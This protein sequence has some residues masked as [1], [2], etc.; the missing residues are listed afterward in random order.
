ML[1]PIIAALLF[2]T[3]ACCAHTQAAPPSI[4]STVI[5][6]NA[7]F[8]I[9]TD[10]LIR[11]EYSSEASFDDRATFTVINR[12]L[13]VPNFT[14]TGGG[15]NGDALI[16]TTAA[17]TLT[18][19]NDNTPLPPL[20]RECGGHAENEV[21]EGQDWSGGY[22][23]GPAEGVP[24]VDCCGACAADASCTSWSVE[25]KGGG[26]KTPLCF[27]YANPPILRFNAKMTA[28]RFPPTP[29]RFG[30]GLSISLKNGGSGATWTPA[31]S[32]NSAQL[33]GTFTD[34]GCY[35]DAMTCLS[36]YW[37]S[38]MNLG[39]V[40]RSG[41]VAIDDSNVPRYIDGKKLNAP[42]PLW[43]TPAPPLI[44]YSDLYI[45][46]YESD[47]VGFLRD[48]S[49]VSGAIA[50]PRRSALG[51]WYGRYYAVTEHDEDEILLAYANFS[52]PLAGLMLD[53]DWHIEP[54]L[55]CLSWG[56]YQWNDTLFPSPLNFSQRVHS[57]TTP[58]GHAVGVSLNIHPQTGIDICESSYPV[59]A[60]RMGINPKTNV[61]IAC[62]M[63]NTTFVQNLYDLILSRETLVI[64]DWWW[65]DFFGCAL[66][67]TG[68]TNVLLWTNILFS[69]LNSLRFP[70]KRPMVLSRSG[71][72][73]TQ[74]LPISFSGDTIQHEATLDFLLQTTP[75]ASNSLVPWWSHDVGG[76][77]IR[78]IGGGTPGDADP[79]NFTACLLLLRWYQ[80]S[81]TFPIF[82]QHCSHCERRIWLFPS[83]F[84][85]LADT[86]R[87]RAALVPY[88]YTS[89]K[90]YGHKGLPIVRPMYYSWPSLNG[91][92]DNNRQHMFGGDDILAAAVSTIEWS[93]NGGSSDNMTQRN[94]WLPP[95]N[96]THWD[97][98]SSILNGNVVIS[99]KVSFNSTPLFVRSGSLIPLASSLATTD[100]TS[101]ISPSLQW[102]LFPST[103]STT[104]KISSFV[105]EDDG[106]ETLDS[107]SGAITS[108]YVTLDNNTNNNI[109][110]LTVESMNGTFYGAPTTRGIEFQIRGWSLVSGGG[111]RLPPSLVSV[112]GVI[113]QP[114]TP[115][116]QSEIVGW[117]IVPLSLHSLTAPFG[118]LRVRAGKLSTSN[119]HLIQVIE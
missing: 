95:G 98:G 49:N 116:T 51:V 61:T 16:I 18:Y 32:I 93:G 89:M 43:F 72:L 118:T 112:D 47:Y 108:A 35:V 2:F 113:L 9:L 64:A 28:H 88:I 114:I 25:V 27:L 106:G 65:T 81:V 102:V 50:L 94:L 110:T 48:W 26:G 87:L 91:A 68:L 19:S 22:N 67:G 37:N 70:N 6:G 11:A 63:T 86:L 23:I 71:G 29:I 46:G 59:F 15:T 84:P 115:D 69:Q 8:T 14:V 101:L 33:N 30:G 41:I 45:N 52:L 66:E 24:L 1:R 76:F 31:T 21:F 3:C 83:V 20:Q 99:I 103:V 44:G 55:P 75:T 105:W 56:Q 4:N 7:R 17:M 79:S 100:N 62:D 109:T 54:Q 96:W 80:A 107:S 39:L 5:S 92:Y 12:A 78:P 10:R 74:R 13:P 82:R 40:A 53:M 85:Y 90:M 117:F 111:G 119:Q 58:I 38:R 34:L 36:Q 60:T 73:G 104:T 97:G 57:G 42:V 77:D